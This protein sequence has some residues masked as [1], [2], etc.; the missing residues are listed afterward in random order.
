[1]TSFGGFQPRHS[2]ALKLIPLLLA[3]IAA[4]AS[5]QTERVLYSFYSEPI[6]IAPIAGVVADKTGALYGTTSYVSSVWKLAPPT[7]AGNPWTFTTIYNFS[8]FQDG[9]GP[10]SLVFDN[11]GGLYGPAAGGGHYGC[12]MVFQLTPSAAGQMWT[13]NVLHNFTGCTGGTDGQKP[14]YGLTML[15]GSLYGITTSGWEFGQGTVYKLTPGESGEP[16]TETVLYSFTGGNDGGI[17]S[18]SLTEGP[19][20]VLYGVAGGGLSGNGVV[21]RLSPPSNGSAQWTEAVLHS[22]GC[23]DNDGCGPSGSLAL[24]QHG[25]LYG[26]VS[27]GFSSLQYGSVFQLTPPTWIETILYAFTDGRDGET[28]KGG[29]ILDSEG[30]LYGTTTGGAEQGQ[31][32][33]SVFKLTPPSVQGNPWSET[34]LHAFTGGSDGGTPLDGLL[35]RDGVL[36]GTT[37]E[38]GPNPDCNCGVVFAVKP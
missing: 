18:S 25:T 3:F 1:M 12:G 15:R 17:P 33:G 4:Q 11:Q 14:F 31:N 20:E 7:E 13:E 6:G 26:T 19:G 32:Q 22:F 35:L 2:L 16:W 9:S 30:A 24:N 34:T 38:G 27:G 10:G 8:G 23:N 21:F 5:A 37:L 28:P 36:Y 29:V